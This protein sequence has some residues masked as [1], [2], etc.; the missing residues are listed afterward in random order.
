MES[1]L[2]ISDDLTVCGPGA[3]KLKLSGQG[4]T[5]VIKVD[6]F[7]AEAPF[8]V[9]GGERIAVELHDISIVNGF[10]T[11]APGFPTDAPFSLPA[12]AF[13][14]GIYNRGR[15]RLWGDGAQPIH[16]NPS[17]DA[18]LVACFASGHAFAIGR[19]RLSGIVGASFFGEHIVKFMNDSRAARAGG[20]R[21]G[22]V[23]R[24]VNSPLH[25]GLVD[26]SL[27][28]E[29][30]VQTYPRVAFCLSLVQKQV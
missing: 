25:C 10:A 8:G 18:R 4:K 26:T 5:R 15:E 19:F 14:G 12:F 16:V 13:G 17:H 1:Q 11:D 3:E 24:V 20:N 21:R 23:A 27:N 30:N 29:L 6:P 2:S 28:G 7:P 22:R 9:P